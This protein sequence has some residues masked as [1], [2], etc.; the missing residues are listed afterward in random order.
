MRSGGTRGGA[1]EF[2]WEDVKND[3]CRECYLGASVKANTGRWQKN[4]DILWYAK[5]KKGD[6]K[7]QRDAEIRAIKE[8]EEDIINQQL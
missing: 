6:L 5:D 2:K 8:E 4:K 3:K 7:A 1:A